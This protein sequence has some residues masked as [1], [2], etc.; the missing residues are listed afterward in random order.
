MTQQKSKLTVA[1][2]KFLERMKLYYELLDERFGKQ[3]ELVRE[4]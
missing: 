3:E 1:Q 4:Q 2:I